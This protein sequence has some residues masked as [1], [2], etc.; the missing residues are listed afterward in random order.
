MGS[1]GGGY[2]LIA[3]HSVE[4]EFALQLAADLRNAGVN[5]WMDRLDLRPQDDWSATLRGAIGSCAALLPVLSPD[6]VASPYG[7]YELQSVYERGQPILPVLL[8]HVH[9]AD[10][11][12]QIGYRQYVD[13]ANWQDRN[14]YAAELEDLLNQ[15]RELNTVAVSGFV[16]PERRYL[17]TLLARIE[18]H[19]HRLE[20]VRLS[21]HAQVFD[22]AETLRPAP[23]IESSWGLNG[24][25]ILR[26]AP[27]DGIRLVTDLRRTLETYP[28]TVLAG[29]SGV[30]KTTTLYRMIREDIG[31]YQNDP[32]RAPLPLLMDLADWPEG[33]SL[34][35]YMRRCWPFMSDMNQ[36]L[37]E[38]RLVLYF[39]GLDEMGRMGPQRA[40]ELR[41]Y[42]AGEQLPHRVMIACRMEDLN[43]ELDLGLPIISL[44]D[45]TESHAQE[46][47]RRY[48]GPLD[49]S[50]LLERLPQPIS[51]HPA[52]DWMLRTPYLLRML[53]FVYM[54]A[55]DAP[56]PANTGR[57]IERYLSLLWEREQ[58]L[59]SPDW[60]P[61]DELLQRLSRLADAMLDDAEPASMSIDYAL[62][63]L[64]DENL[65][66]SLCSAGILART[67]NGVRFAHAMLQ[68]YCLAIQMHESRLHDSLQRPVFDTD[69]MRLN[70]P[71]DLSVILLAGLVEDSGLFIDEVSQVDP[72]LATMILTRSAPISKGHWR[73]IVL[74]L[75]HYALREDSHG[76]QAAAQT[77]E[78]LSEQVPVAPIL[79]LMREGPRQDRL[80]AAEALRLFAFPISPDLSAAIVQ[81]NGGMSDEV[82]DVI[83]S[84]GEE[85]LP[86]FLNMLHDVDELRRR[87][88]CWV[89]GMLSDRAAVPD[90]IWVLRNDESAVVRREAALALR[91]LSDAEAVADLLLALRDIDSGVR[92]AASQALA[93]A[94]VSAVPGLLRMA[95]DKRPDVRR[96]AIGVLGWVG[97]TATLPDLVGYLK[98][99]N[100]DVRAMAVTA[101]GQIGDAR[102][103]APLGRCL[104]DQARP[105]WTSHTVA[106][107][108]AQALE[109][110]GTEEAM[111]IVT[112]WRGIGLNGNK[113]SAAQAKTKLQ[114]TE[115]IQEPRKANL[116]DI[117]KALRHKDWRIRE[118]AVQMLARL[119]HPRALPDLRVAMKDSDQQVRFAAVRALGPLPAE[120]VID[121]LLLALEDSEY[122]VSDTAANLLVA[123]GIPAV[124]GLLR[125]ATHPVVDVRGL[126]IEALG[127]IGDDRAVPVLMAAVSDAAVP[128]WEDKSIG[129]IAAES[130]R[131]I[132]HSMVENQTVEAAPLPV[133]VEDP[134]EVPVESTF[135]ISTTPKSP[136]ISV[137]A[138]L[139]RLTH[140]LEKLQ[141]DEWPVR[142]AAAK[143]LTRY[144]RSLQDTDARAVIERL[145]TYLSNPEEFVRW[146]TIEA[147][148]WI[149]DEQVIP[150]LLPLLDDD[151]WTI[152][153]AVLRALAEIGS[154]KALPGLMH[155]LEDTHELVREVAVE[156]IG[157]MQLSG[158]LPAL[159]A[160][161]HDNAGFVRRAAV[162]AIGEIGAQEVSDELIEMLR[163]T[164]DQQIRWAIVE[165]LGKLGA[166]DAVDLLKQYL[167]DTYTPIWESL[168][169]QEQRRLCDVAAQA[170]ERIATPQALAALRQWRNAT[171]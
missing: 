29:A 2:I 137:Q 58:V 54:H 132:G 69:G 144:T 151:V 17:T 6:Y 27:H 76:L 141:E 112:R 83:R 163:T 55:P 23:R 38:D 22:P 71:G 125:L 19:R 30:G 70:R 14:L 166:A 124:D 130:L 72:Y 111:S 159:R 118:R 60:I 47:V 61:L 142:Q 117:R 85:A 170:L 7:R 95:R 115:T 50:A 18:Q 46:L 100:A 51:T 139:D 63:Y 13:F 148:A 11:P 40:A 15:I 75:L 45:M 102:V 20:F 107:L 31:V 73:R 43:A 5:L 103:I 87:G 67:E 162:E 121:D 96:I 41:E 140:L 127:R 68:D 90:L 155:A 32:R 114:R 138:R 44:E 79:T 116:S 88:A 97:D 62:R 164:E 149:A 158:A 161:L 171:T 49:G 99:N 126:A 64:S 91:Q 28:H 36:W 123:I 74:R 104:K 131:T 108:A 56:L 21:Y 101:L 82:A 120:L 3:Y 26:R 89:L 80:L 153:T 136:V 81:W 135:A 122:L 146:T 94:G 133:E 86:L 128:R 59:Q 168:E 93:D 150:A 1:A 12:P 39:D 119:R 113:T 169:D 65:I 156:V 98:D 4:S 42:L 106:E 10:W 37:A 35:G 25:F 152:R 145:V 143:E 78:T 110:I 9:A 34:Q 165:A 105:R 92:K 167:D 48:L 77:I 8:R 16:N 109:K 24:P 84:I 160:A 33:E 157:Q 66:F 129:D 57:L 147:L 154:E 134:Y 52:F 53:M